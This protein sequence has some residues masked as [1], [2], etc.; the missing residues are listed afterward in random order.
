[1]SKQQFVDFRAV[2]QAVSMIQIL[3][4]YGLT[5]QMKRN[6][7]GQ[8]LSGKCPLHNGDNPTQ[9]RASLEK[10][11]WNC[12]G[13]CRGGGN[14][15]DFVARKE[16]CTIREAALRISDWFKLPSPTE[17]SRTRTSPP[18]VDKPESGQRKAAPSPAD[19]P[20]KSAGNKPL[21]FELKNLDPAHPYFAERG[22]GPETVSVFRLGFCNIGSMAGRIVIPIQNPAGELVAYAGRWPGDPPEGTSKYKLPTG[23][24]KSLD[25]FNLHRAMEEPETQPLV[26]VEGFFDAIKLWQNGVRRVVALMGC[27]L[28]PAQEALIVKHTS[29]QTKVLVMLDEDEAGRVG[30]EQ[31]VQRLALHRYVKFFQFEQEGMQPDQLTAADV[32]A[33]FPKKG[34]SH[35]RAKKRDQVPAGQDGNNGACP[36]PASCP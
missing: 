29:L 4:H 24:G 13:Q 10:N 6:G 7:N 20:E 1:M 30:R 5:D 23:F 15:L 21:S 2:K 12:F 14:V 26:I 36:S 22:I 35:A 32:A 18:K 25:L 33:L 28:S 27:S 19:S 9:F 11:V 8:S 31:V 34:G 3:D 17:E 16:D